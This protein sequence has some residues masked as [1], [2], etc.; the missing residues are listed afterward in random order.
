MDTGLEGFMIMELSITKDE[1][2]KLMKA[3]RTGKPWTARHIMALRLL[4]DDDLNQFM[5][6][7]YSKGHDWDC[8]VDMI[9]AIIRHPG[10]QRIPA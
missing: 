10:S 7:W 8:I 5:R 9:E 1:A 3:Y 4:I 6:L 2:W